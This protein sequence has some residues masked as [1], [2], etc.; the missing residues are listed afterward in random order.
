MEAICKVNEKEPPKVKTA[1]KTQVKDFLNNILTLD[2]IR[3]SSTLIR[4]DVLNILNQK[5]KFAVIVP[6]L[7]SLFE[8][9][10]SYPEYSY[11]I[12]KIRGIFSSFN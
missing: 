12:G 8:F 11:V 6:D 5:D 4:F 7:I 2:I 1:K 3:L 10:K 9:D